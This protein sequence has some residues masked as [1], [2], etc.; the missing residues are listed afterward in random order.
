MDAV[1][2]V[3][4]FRFSRTEGAGHF[5]TFLESRRIA[6][7]LVRLDQG[8]AVP[9]SS[10]PFAGLALMGGP[11][12]ANDDLPWT[13]PVLA[14]L[15]DAVA[16]DVPVI[17]HCLGGQ[18]LARSLGGNVSRNPVKEI[19]WNRVQIEDTP[20]AREWFGP[21]LRRFHTFQ[22]HGETF[23]LPV[24]AE[25]ILTGPHCANQGYVA[26]GRHLG[27]QCH[28][29]MTPDMIRSWCRSGYEEVMENL[30]SPAVQTVERMQAEMAMRLPELNR[31]AE[32]LY[33]RWVEGLRVGRSIEPARAP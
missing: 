18:L 1:K 21:E 3:M 11:M 20:L 25:R 29:E 4:V 27:L 13:E 14:L 24:G 19:G 16:N 10:A 8:E 9:E 6:W 17:G 15:R 26:A 2:P 23:T 33:S 30:S 7:H 31:T 32:R 28:V 12:S 22:W 5:A